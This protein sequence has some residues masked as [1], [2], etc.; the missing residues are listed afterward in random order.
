[1]VAYDIWSAMASDPDLSAAAGVKVRRSTF[2]F[3]Q[4]I[5]QDTKQ[6]SKMRE[7]K[8]SG[9]IG[10]RRDPDMIREFDVSSTYGAIDAYEHL[11]PVI[12]TDRCMAFLTELVR[13]KGATLVTEIIRGDLFSQEDFLLA[14]F[15]AD[16]IVNAT[17]LA[18]IELAADKSCYP[19]RGALL[20]LINDGKDFPKVDAALTITADP[21]HSPTEIVFI[22]PRNDNILL[23]GGIAQGHQWDLDLTLDSSIIQGM[24]NR[25]EAFLPGLRDARLDPDYP[26]AQGLRPF[27]TGNVRVESEPRKHGGWRKSRIVH[28]YGHG[29]S[30][31][32]LT[33]GCAA[34]VVALIEN[35]VHTLSAR[36]IPPPMRF[37]D[38]E[39]VMIR[40]RL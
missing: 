31:W 23:L 36:Y 28:S 10:F 27:R 12:D 26:L 13:G 16:A 38:D 4:P 6:L 20:R 5:E 33:F 37:V 24:R 34:D 2:F 19:Y 35:A 29:G 11:A 25:C 14:R 9:V 17:G 18:S 15:D 22:L 1:M 7:I 30:G 40:S 8:G 39:N 21:A 32:S 3:P